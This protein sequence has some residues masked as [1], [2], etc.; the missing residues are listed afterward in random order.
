MRIRL[1]GYLY[2]N[3][4]KTPGW[5]FIKPDFACNNPAPVG[6]IPN[7]EITPLSP[8]SE[9]MHE[10]IRTYTHYLFHVRHARPIINH[11]EQNGVPFEVISG[12][13]NMYSLSE[14]YIHKNVTSLPIE[15]HYPMSEG[16]K[17]LMTDLNAIDY[18]LQRYKQLIQMCVNKGESPQE[19]QALFDYLTASFHARYGHAGKIINK[20]INN[21]YEDMFDIVNYIPTAI[22][23]IISIGIIIYYIRHFYS[24]NKYIFKHIITKKWFQ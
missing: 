3:T 22:I 16:K 2:W 1:W 13:R 21:T 14:V 6:F 18:L 10:A 9:I 11:F 24:C 5:E 12:S 20:Y 7:P 23:S 8:L 17:L 4:Q 19:L 15:V